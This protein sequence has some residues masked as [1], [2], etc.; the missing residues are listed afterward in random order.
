MKCA[1]PRQC[2]RLRPSQV[3][4]ELTSVY[5]QKPLTPRDERL[6]I[7]VHQGN[8]P[9][10]FYGDWTFYSRNKDLQI[11]KAPNFPA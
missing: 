11:Q 5:S 6:I 4:E 1:V 10:K 8:C 2:N 9:G 3:R 7:S